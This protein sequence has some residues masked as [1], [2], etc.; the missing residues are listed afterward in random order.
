M[1]S[2]QLLRLARMLKQS[3]STMTSPI[4]L[5]A[6]ENRSYDPE[7]DIMNM[8]DATLLE[9][10]HIP[11]KYQ[12]LFKPKRIRPLHD[13]ISVERTTYPKIIN[14]PD[15]RAL[16]AELK[17][18]TPAQ[19]RLQGRKLNRVETYIVEIKESPQFYTHLQSSLW[20]ICRVE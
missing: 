10:V 12:D 5:Q 18:L 17:P 3:P 2:T 13:A 14:S 6:L 1:S 15:I 4:A 20:D 8:S 9:S 16:D 11:G 7:T 19:Q